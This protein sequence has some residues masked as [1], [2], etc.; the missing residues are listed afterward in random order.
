MRSPSKDIVEMFGFAPDDVSEDSRRFFQS[1]C[2]PFL[3]ST[4]TK[5]NHDQSEIYGACSVTSGRNE[6]II[7]PKR[8][9]AN[10]YQPFQDVKTRIWGEVPLIVGGSSQELRQKALKHPECVVAFGQNSGGEVT[11][12][13]NGKLSIDWILQRYQKTAGRLIPVDF[14]ALEVQSIDITGNYRDNFLAYKSLREGR[15]VN[16]IPL[17]GH[18]L[19][20][21][22]VHKRL[23]PQIIRKGN[24]Y[25]HMGRCVAFVFV[26]PKIVYEKF[27]KILGD[28]E[29]EQSH[30]RENLTV[31]TYSLGKTTPAGSMRKLV[32]DGVKHHL[33][34]NIVFAF[35]RNTQDGA[36]EA[37][38][39]K[40]KAL[41]Y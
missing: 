35:S 26:L 4:C 40:L 24:I 10:T 33:L 38:E 21:A 8:L 34:S 27:D 17:A 7:C 31:F 36:P 9:Y 15:P 23:I 28:V 6:V 22:N 25:H 3:G 29:E 5:T 19:N 1:R 11:I 18:G 16:F 13:S 37:L 2:C 32:L 39:S 30:S 20:W 12:N 41:L 14:A